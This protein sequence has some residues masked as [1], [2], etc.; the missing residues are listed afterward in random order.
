MLRSTQQFVCRTI[1]NTREKWKLNKAHFVSL[2][3]NFMLSCNGAR[4]V[5]LLD[6]YVLVCTMCQ[7]CKSSQQLT[8]RWDFILSIHIVGRDRTPSLTQ[9]RQWEKLL[10]NWYFTLV[11][12]NDRR[13]NDN[14]TL[15]LVDSVCPYK[16][17]NDE[18]LPFIILHVICRTGMCTFWFA[19][20][21]A[22]R[23]LC[24]CV[25]YR[26]RCHRQCIFYAGN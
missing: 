16:F 4:V 10:L 3:I 22:I 19:A 24:C 14:W 26:R 5:S 8:N 7:F 2:T 25:R 6:A 21:F 11:F 17:W 9:Y 20:D 15:R 13:C 12:T 18:K 1:H 23:V